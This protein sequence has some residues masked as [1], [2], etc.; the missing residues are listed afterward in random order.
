ME[1]AA[2]VERAAAT[3][4]VQVGD[5][6]ALAASVVILIAYA[7]LPLRSDSPSTGLA[8][9][10]SATTLPVLTLVIGLVVLL[11]ALVNLSV[12]RESGVRWWYAGLGLLGLLF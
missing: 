5:I 3:P 8:F 9:I 12:I 1:N 7:V 4:S 2:R 11:S 6:V 10:D